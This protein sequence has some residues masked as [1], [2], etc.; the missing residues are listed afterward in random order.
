ME[1]VIMIGYPRAAHTLI[2]L[3]QAWKE[4]NH[5]VAAFMAQKITGTIYF[6]CL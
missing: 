2:R 5:S 4:G 6:T 3:F 1:A